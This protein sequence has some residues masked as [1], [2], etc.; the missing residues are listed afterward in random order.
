M[1]L[2][3]IFGKDLSRSTINFLN[4]FPPCHRSSKNFK[5]KFNEKGY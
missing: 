3:D 5:R 4:N 2:E 1:K